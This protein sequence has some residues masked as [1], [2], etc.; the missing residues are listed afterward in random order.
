M[1]LEVTVLKKISQTLEEKR[2]LTCSQMWSLKK[3][4]ESREEAV[5]V[6][7]DSG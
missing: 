3:S 1:K 4:C 5:R 6:G 2:S 7:K